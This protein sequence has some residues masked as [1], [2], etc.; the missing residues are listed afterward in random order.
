MAWKGEETEE[1]TTL[2]KDDIKWAQWLR[3]ARNFQLRV[4]LKER[5]QDAPDG[6]KERNRETFDGFLREVSFFASTDCGKLIFYQG[7]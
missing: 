6:A 7:S 2:H 1:V 5:K 4:G 3:V